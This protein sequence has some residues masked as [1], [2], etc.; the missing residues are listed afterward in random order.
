MTFILPLIY[1]AVVTIHAYLDFRQIQKGIYIKHKTEAYW[2]ALA[3]FILFW[4]L[5]KWS[6]PI[7]LIIFPLI[8]RAALFNFMLCLFRG[9]NPL[10]YIGEKKNKAWFDKIEEMVG[11]PVWLLRLFY[12]LIYVIYLILYVINAN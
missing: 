10:T 6:E 12:L 2:F 5:L 11:L 9:K 7:P 3:C 1:F 4:G 8:T